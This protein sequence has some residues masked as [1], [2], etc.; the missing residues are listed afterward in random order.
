MSSVAA[1]RMVLP[2]AVILSI[3][4]GVVNVAFPQ[5]VPA[6]AAD[7]FQAFLAARPK[8]QATSLLAMAGV[9]WAVLAVACFGMWRGRRWGFVLGV[10]VTVITVVQAFLLAPHA[11]SG[12][13]FALSYVAKILWGAALALAY[14]SSS[15][16]NPA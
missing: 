5:L 9:Y 14:V 3:V 1:V 13:G 4:S 12:L 7:A 6:G 10:A 15:T 8:G 2:I 16:S 11:Y